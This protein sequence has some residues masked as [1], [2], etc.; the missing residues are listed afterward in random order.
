VRFAARGRSYKKGCERIDCAPSKIK[1]SAKEKIMKQ[2]P[3][4]QLLSLLLLLAFSSSAFAHPGHGASGLTAGLLHPFSGM[5]HL[6]AMLAVGLWAGQHGGRK[7][8]LLPAVFMTLLAA[9]AGVALL[10]PTLPMIETGIAASVLVLGLIIALSLQLPALSG[11]ALT[12]AFGFVH[13]YAH[14]LEMPATAGPALYALGFLSA[15]AILHVTGISLGLATRGQFA[16]WIQASGA[17]IALSG[18][19]LLN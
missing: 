3:A 17:L 16:R 14:G 11:I 9:G 15:T 10:Y 13:G 1:N 12:A 7:V 5:D 6:L 4:T 18:I 2:K 8:W 19:W